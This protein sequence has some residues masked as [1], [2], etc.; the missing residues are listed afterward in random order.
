MFKK[1]VERE[2][3]TRAKY[4]LGSQIKWKIVIDCDK[5]IKILKTYIDQLEQEDYEPSATRSM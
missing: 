3:E 1:E 4:N 2:Q 5:R